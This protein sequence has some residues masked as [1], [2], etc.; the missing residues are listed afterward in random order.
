MAMVD[1]LFR[2]YLK[3]VIWHNLFVGASILDQNPFFEKAYRSLRF[4]LI[5]LTALA[6]IMVL[7]YCRPA[8]AEHSDFT[9]QSPGL[10]HI[11]EFNDYP[12]GEDHW[13]AKTDWRKMRNDRYDRQNRLKKNKDYRDRKRYSQKRKNRGVHQQTQRDHRRYLSKRQSKK[14]WQDL[15]PEEQQRIRKQYKEW[16]SLSPQEKQKIR[17]RKNELDRMPP[18]KQKMYR[19][20]YRQ[21]QHMSSQERKQIQKDLNNWENLSPQ[22]QNAIRRRFRQ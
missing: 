12:F 22:E 19:E 9:N 15:S 16:Q 4:Q 6:G 2:N 7:F 3:K 10:V 5:L 17:Q 21:W 1:I 20:L 11:M 8:W 18:Q 14:R 13:W